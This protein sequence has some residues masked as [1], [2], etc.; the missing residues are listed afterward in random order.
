M[1]VELSTLLVTSNLLTG[2]NQ[3]PVFLKKLRQQAMLQALRTRKRFRTVVGDVK[4]TDNFE[5]RVLKEG[6]Q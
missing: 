3:P 5:L 1:N 6:I 4:G 2:F